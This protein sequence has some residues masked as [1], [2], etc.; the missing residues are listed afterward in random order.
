VIDHGVRF[1]RLL[2]CSDLIPRNSRFGRLTFGLASG[3]W[4]C[5]SGPSGVGKSS[6]LFALAGLCKSISGRIHFCGSEPTGIRA[7]S[8][9]SH[10]QHAPYLVPQSLP[11]FSQ[12]DI[13]QNVLF[14]QSIS[15]NRASPEACRDLLIKMGLQ[16]RLH[17]LP[18]QLS[19]GEKQRVCVAL[20]L[21][22]KTPVVLIDEPTS[23]L[24]A[25]CVSS[26]IR[27]FQE[28]T[29]SGRSLLVVSNDPRLTAFA[30]GML[31]LDFEQE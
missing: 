19:V 31:S 17:S 29:Q 18:S 21:A 8:F 5:V 24:D 4:I 26:L 28:A 16:D 25:D 23:N 30:D 11:L 14:V 15:G 1:K 13:L 6:L 3:E 27:V 9:G 12:L 2:E 10:R 7:I 20:G 22:T